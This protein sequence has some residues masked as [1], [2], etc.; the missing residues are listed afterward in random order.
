MHVPT[1]ATLPSL[2]ALA[3]A[4]EPWAVD[5]MLPA[6][7]A[8]RDSSFQILA[9][10]GLLVSAN[11]ARWAHAYAE[12]MHTEWLD[13]PCDVARAAG[14][15]DFKWA[16][17]EECH[18]QMCAWAR[19]ERPWHDEKALLSGRGHQPDPLNDG[20]R[21]RT[22]F[23]LMRFHGEDDQ[24]WFAQVLSCC[25][26]QRAGQCAAAMRPCSTARTTQGAGLAL[27]VE[28]AAIALM[29][30]VVTRRAL[31]ID[32][33]TAPTTAM[34]ELVHSPSLELDALGA[35]GMSEAEWAALQGTRQHEAKIP[36]VKDF[37]ALHDREWLVTLNPSRVFKRRHLLGLAGASAGSGGGGLRTWLD[38]LA[39]GRF[40][41]LF[42]KLLVKIF[43]PTA[44]FA[45][46]LHQ[47]WS[48]NFDPHD[49]VVGVALR[50]GRMETID[51]K[52]DPLSYGA[53]SPDV[54]GRTIHCARQ[55]ATSI[56]A[57]LTAAPAAAHAAARGV[58]FFVISD[59]EAIKGRTLALLPNSRALGCAGVPFWRAHAKADME[60]ILADWCAAQLRPAESEPPRPAARCVWCPQRTQRVCACACVCVSACGCECVCA[61]ASACVCVC[62]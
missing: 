38:S 36:W 30:S 54:F 45:Q 42:G 29:Y 48:A 39:D 55:T 2:A 3:A 60:C 12:R 6:V 24:G 14:G 19:A 47:W 20:V 4:P 33:D 8:L 46:R 43:Q 34:R 16:A 52:D 15:F 57:A 58:A 40:F 1:G 51:G 17:Y 11:A 35:T 23:T 13:E 26:I 56:A 53:A 31:V 62:A 49:V 44:S 59:N 18:R 7:S 21:R 5:V 61:F 41:A 25:S 9:K 27:Q 10:V 37:D 50:T 32:F 22:R 28:N